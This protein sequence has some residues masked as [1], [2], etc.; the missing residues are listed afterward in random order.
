MAIDSVFFI[1]KAIEKCPKQHMVVIHLSKFDCNSDNDN[2]VV[3]GQSLKS[4]TATA[5]SKPTGEGTSDSN[6]T[7]T[8][9]GANPSNLDN[10][11]VPKDSKIKG[12]D[13]EKDKKIPTTENWELLHLGYLIQCDKVEDVAVEEEEQKRLRDALSKAAI[14]VGEIIG[15]GILAATGNPLGFVPIYVNFESVYFHLQ[16]SRHSFYIPS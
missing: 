14:G 7:R 11:G 8:E 10:D 1:L 15:G 16:L 3:D 9:S 5:N 4:E 6:C 12:K 13:K 2:T